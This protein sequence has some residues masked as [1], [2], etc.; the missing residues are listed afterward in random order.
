MSKAKIIVEFAEG[1]EQNDL[2]DALRVL[3]ADSLVLWLRAAGFH[4]NVEGPDFGPYHALFGS[5]VDDVYATLDVTAEHL[6][7][8]GMY[9]PFT[10]PAFQKYR[11]IEDAPVADTTSA[12]F[13]ADLLACNE[14]LLADIA[15]AKALAKE[16][17]N[18]G[19]YLDDLRDGAQ[20][21]AWFLRSSLK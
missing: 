19:N 9:A 17:P 1:S 8:L 18:L 16:E 12:T 21:R 10:L 7:K 14:T 13:V 5:I 2:V 20:K 4:W 11:T 6:R 15:A 3:L